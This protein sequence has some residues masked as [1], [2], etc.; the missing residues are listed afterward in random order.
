MTLI[1]NSYFN[2][3]L[4]EYFWNSRNSVNQFLFCYFL[5]SYSPY[6]GYSPYYSFICGILEIALI[7]YDLFFLYL[8]LIIV[9]S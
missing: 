9:V 4:K 3:S 6:L 1:P 8:F 7:P 2:L 5:I